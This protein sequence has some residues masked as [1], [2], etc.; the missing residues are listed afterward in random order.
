M[1]SAAAMEEAKTSSAGSEKDAPLVKEVLNFHPSH[2]LE[3]LLM[4]FTLDYRTLKQHKQ[5]VKPP[6]TIVRSCTFHKSR[7]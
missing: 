3:L 2:D 4:A 5:L 6:T 7:G 1:N